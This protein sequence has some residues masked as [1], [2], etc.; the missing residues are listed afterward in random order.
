MV[1]RIEWHSSSMGGTNGFVNGKLLF[2]ISYGL[3]QPPHG[4]DHYV[5]SGEL[6]VATSKGHK[7]EGIAKERAERVLEA[8]IWRL[9]AT[10]PTPSDQV[11]GEAPTAFQRWW[12]RQQVAVEGTIAAEW[13]E[14]LALRAFAEGLKTGR[15]ELRKELDPEPVWHI[16][17]F[18]E[19]GWTVKHPLAC[20]EGDLFE[21][22][23][24]KALVELANEP[25]KHP[26][27][28][29]YTVRVKDDG[30]EFGPRTEQ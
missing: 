11:A 30:L 10:L 15:E 22:P 16:V 21:C 18:D 23:T 3:M 19:D 14:G 6:P 26:V 7:T 29:T 20:R 9:G 25:D 12:Q 27:P 13:V 5:L 4:N 17:R 28:G 1:N 2:N 8:F 24:N